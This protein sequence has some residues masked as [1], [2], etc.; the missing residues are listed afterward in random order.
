VGVAHLHFRRT[1]YKAGGQKA[2]RRIAY[3]TRTEGKRQSDSARHLKYLTQG[4]EDLVAAG[5]RNLPAWAPDARTYFAAAEQYEGANRVAFE[6]WKIT[7]PVELAREDNL[8][9]VQDLLDT[10]AGERLP[11]TWAMHAPLTLDGTGEQPHLHL[12]L[13]SRMNDAHTRTPDTHFKLWQRKA[14][15]QGGAQKDP[16]FWSKGAVKAH[17]L[18]VADMLNIHLEA[19]RLTARV[20]PETL[21]RRGI[22]R[23]P[24]PKLLPSESA[25]FREQGAVGKTMGEVLATRKARTKQRTR[26]DNT[27]YQAW[28][29]RKAFLGIDRAMPREEKIAAIL[30]KRHGKVAQVP[31]RYRP[32]AEA[33]ERRRQRGKERQD[34]R[35]LTQQIAA[36]TARLEDEE[37][38]HGRGVHVRVWD[39]EKE[40][41]MGW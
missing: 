3:I 25:A 4:R 19:H 27:A 7:L 39:R 8:A 15:E 11:C 41:G 35:S 9:L 5:T 23:Q 2:A 37:Q 31:A 33:Q 13:S 16:A 34:T 10:I 26:E 17:R 30:L 20:D 36:L 22:Q 14:P 29:E 28:E 21:A 38:A 40:Q 18:M 12:L 32:L 6:E 24:E 1:V